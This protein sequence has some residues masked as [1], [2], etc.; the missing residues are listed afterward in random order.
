MRTKNNYLL[1]AAVIT[2]IVLLIYITIDQSEK[3]MAILGG[4]TAFASVVLT[5]LINIDR[6]KLDRE[7]IEAELLSSVTKEAYK[8][9][10]N[11]K[12][13]AYKELQGLIRDYRNEAASYIYEEHGF[14]HETGY[15]ETWGN[16]PEGVFA[17]H[18]RKILNFL[19]ANELVLSKKL[20]SHYDK[21]NKTYN[22][23]S[24]DAEAW[25]HQVASGSPDD[26]EEGHDAWRNSVY[27]KTKGMFDYLA[28][29]LDE[30]VDYIRE[31][32]SF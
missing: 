21:I 16:T 28:S 6:N 27:A 12:V 10:F 13:G 20:Y 19:K 25:Q 1:L 14:N 15:P 24:A 30:E 8:D 7:K 3:S 31:K 11:Q 17:D 2:I 4:L 9:M 22:E 26:W 18:L 29:D 32:I 23:I 5:A